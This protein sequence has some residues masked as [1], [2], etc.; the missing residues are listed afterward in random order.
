MKAKHSLRF[1]HISEH[2]V[3]PSLANDIMPCWLW[4][5]GSLILSNLQPNALNTYHNYGHECML[6]AHIHK[7]DSQNGILENAK[8]SN[9]HTHAH[10]VTLALA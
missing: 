6:S 1:V 5:F 7:L 2:C 9:T 3:P 8:Y 4:S 10:A